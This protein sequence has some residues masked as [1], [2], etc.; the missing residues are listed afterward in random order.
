MQEIID[1][2]EREGLKVAS[3][4]KRAIAMAIDDFLISLVV[5]IAFF[6]AFSKV[7]TYEEMLIL[8]DKLFIY[9]FITYTLYHWFFVVFYGKTIGKM[10]VKI[11]VIDVETLDKPN[12]LRAFIRSLFR[13]FD[14]MFFYLGMAYAIVDPLNRAIHDVVGKAVVV[15]DN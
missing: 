9:I 6:D 10:I 13:N 15:E 12:H 4:S 1:K 5:V 14:E 7:K 2:L 3:L 8:T 11:K